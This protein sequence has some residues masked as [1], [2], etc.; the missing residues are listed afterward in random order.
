M[1]KIPDASALGIATPQAPGH[2]PRVSG[3]S[4]I[5]DAVAGFGAAASD[6]LDK[7]YENQADL[8][9]SAAKGE[10]LRGQIDLQTGILNTE[11]YNGWQKSFEDGTAKLRQGIAGK[12]SDPRR[13]AAFEN[14]TSIEAARV[15]A[16]M[17]DKAHA[18]FKQTQ[19]QALD[20]GADAD[21][22]SLVSSGDETTRAQILRARNE[23]IDSG[24]KLG[25]Y[26]GEQAAAKKRYIAETYAKGRA[27]TMEPYSRLD[28][29]QK[30]MSVDADGHIA[31]G[32]TGT[33]FDFL[34]PD[35][36]VQLIHATKI[37]IAQLEAANKKEDEAALKSEQN[38]LL[39]KFQQHKLGATD[40]ANSNLHPFG[41]G[42]KNQFF[43][44]LE[45]QAKEGKTGET[46]DDQDLVVDLFRRIH[47]PDGDPNKITDDMAL[48]KYYGN[49]I[50]KISTM[51]DL[52]N[53]T[54]GQNTEEGAINSQLKKNIVDEAQRALV[55]ANPFTGIMDPN[56]A[57]GRA[58]LSKFTSW[59][60]Q[61]YAA[62]VHA[63]KRPMDLL[64]ANSKDYL[65]R[66]I[67]SFRVSPEDAM[68]AQAEAFRKKPPALVVPTPAAAAPQ[69]KNA[70]LLQPRRNAGET[71]EQFLNRQAQG[72]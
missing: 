9:F 51:N 46:K 22:Q 29:L 56:D 52:R 31:F 36:R 40:V 58:Q 27:E 19:V 62:Q 24:V 38:D 3:E 71:P 48:N 69:L 34:R 35:E 28:A 13:R 17:A 45:I 68:A 59:F 6:A 64:D 23:Q 21:I 63:G 26:S 60:M 30:G 39:L 1:A 55:K 72:Q 57:A 14:E 66:Q 15:S 16:D 33:S 53:E 49:G 20:E 42:S 8:A 11:D 54:Q 4:A 32:K 47:L 18:R 61:Q 2:A 5:P 67:D 70:P 43:N 44:M 7:H 41:E 10:Y 25:L 65:G 50:N 37:D 12:L